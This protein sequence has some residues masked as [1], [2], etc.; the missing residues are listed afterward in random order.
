MFSLNTAA[1]FLMSNVTM[2]QQLFSSKGGYINSSKAF[3]MSASSTLLVI[4][5]RQH[6]VSSKKMCDIPFINILI[7]LNT[8]SIILLLRNVAKNSESLTN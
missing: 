1:G 6:L 4:L 3:L 7:T 8:L 5:V 2:G